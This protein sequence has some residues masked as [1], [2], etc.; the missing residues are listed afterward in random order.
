MTPTLV[1][2]S[3]YGYAVRSSVELVYLRAGSFGDPLTIDVAEPAADPVGEPAFRWEPREGQEFSGRLWLGGDRYRLL[4]DREGWFEIDP[5]RPW[6]GVPADTSP[7][8]RERRIWGIPA[9]LCFI[10][11]GDVSLH[12]AAVE[13]DGAAVLLAAPGRFGK[14]T[15]SAG[16]LRA[17]HRVL[18]E[19]ISCCRPGERPSVFPGPAVLR[20]R[21]DVYRRLS[22]PGVRPV[23]EELDRIHLTFDAESRGGGDPLPIRSIVLLRKNEDGGSTRMEPVPPTRALPDLWALAWRLPETADVVRC[24]DGVTQLASAVPVFNLHRT[25]SFE[26]LDEVVGAIVETCSRV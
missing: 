14:T 13:I 10:R 5:D 24:F 12:A 4:S 18:S 1:T 15:L 2:G 6:I 16:F 17:G 9:V 11:R 8:V 7:L 19:D 26:T 20:L 25:L 21:R 22:L 3:V 23:A